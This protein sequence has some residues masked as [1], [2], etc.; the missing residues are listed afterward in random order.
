MQS[1]KEETRELVAARLAAEAAEEAAAREAPRGAADVDTDDE[2]DEEAAYE[3]WRLRELSRIARDRGEREREAAEA[4]E[5]ERWRGLTEE[6]RVRELAARG[7]A[8][9]AEKPKKKWRFLQKYWH[10]GAFFQDAG[11]TQAAEP[12]AVGD[13]AGRDFSAPTG[14][15]LF[16][17]ESMPRVMQKRNF[18]RRGQTK[19]THLVDQ[20]TTT[21]DSPW[22]QVRGLYD[23]VLVG[24]VYKWACGVSTWGPEARECFDPGD[25]WVLMP[26]LHAL[27]ACRHACQ[28]PS[29]YP[30]HIQLINSISPPLILTTQKDNIREKFNKKLAGTEEVFT[31]PTRTKT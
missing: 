8:A 2:R 28:A 7:K 13:L 31:R 29:G 27:C 4:A 11:D 12:P 25:T 14:E 15:D 5:R 21:W 6:E 23:W 9:E 26:Q 3:A 22:M 24:H 16:D 20:D 1:R 19:W 30:I 10:R 18:G 17:R